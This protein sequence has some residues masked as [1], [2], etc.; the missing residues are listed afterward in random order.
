[1]LKAI[2]GTVPSGKHVMIDMSKYSDGS[3][4]PVP[5]ILLRAVLSR[6]GPSFSRKYKYFVD[7][8]LYVARF[9]SRTRLT[10]T[11]VASFTQR[12][13][14]IVTA[15]TQHVSPDEVDDFPVDL[16]WDQRCFV[17]YAGFPRQYWTDVEVDKPLPVRLLPIWRFTSGIDGEPLHVVRAAV[18]QLPS[19]FEPKQVKTGIPGYKPYPSRPYCP[20]KTFGRQSTGHRVWVFHGTST[21]DAALGIFKSGFDSVRARPGFMG[22]GA[23]VSGSVQVAR[24]YGRYIVVGILTLPSTTMLRSPDSGLLDVEVAYGHSHGHALCMEFR[25]AQCHMIRVAVLECGV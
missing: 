9:T 24:L 10:Q 8:R 18:P 25:Y 16:W 1:M 22:M 4:F 6:S 7:G 13:L 11:A 2:M 15:H 12:Q 19:T 21:L 17:G 5:S 14:C 23:Y 3:V 20:E